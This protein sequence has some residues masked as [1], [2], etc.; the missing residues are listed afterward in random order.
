M[1]LARVEIVI[2]FCD[3]TALRKILERGFGLVFDPVGH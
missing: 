1:S 3:C 2:V